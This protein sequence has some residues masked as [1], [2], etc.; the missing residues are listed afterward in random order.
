MSQEE[1][2]REVRKI[3]FPMPFDLLHTHGR[4]L[5]RLDLEMLIGPEDSFSDDVR[6]FD[7]QRGLAMLDS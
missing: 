7:H 3:V 1:M 6:S 5:A 2:V 4:G